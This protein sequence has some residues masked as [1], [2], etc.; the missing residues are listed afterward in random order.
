MGHF[1]QQNSFS[2]TVRRCVPE[3]RRS[4]IMCLLPF[5]TAAVVFQA[6]KLSFP[7]FQRLNLGIAFGSRGHGLHILEGKN[8]DSQGNSCLAAGHRSVQAL[9]SCWSYRNDRAGMWDHFSETVKGSPSMLG[10]WHLSGKHCQTAK[11]ALLQSSNVSYV[12]SINSE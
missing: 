6:R 9:D 11:C 1:L 7:W 3:E 4:C 2:V 12:G 10:T 5:P 8:R